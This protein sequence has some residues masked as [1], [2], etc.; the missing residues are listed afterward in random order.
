MG[1]TLMINNGCMS[2]IFDYMYK[3]FCSNTEAFIHRYRYLL[4]N[5]FF[6]LPNWSSEILFALLILIPKDPIL[7]SPTF[8]KVDIDL[9]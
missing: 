9:Q 5:H 7:K 1:P 8:R 4:E 2:Q 3:Y 6:P